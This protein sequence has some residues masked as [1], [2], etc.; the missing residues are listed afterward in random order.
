MDDQQR[1]MKIAAFALC[2]FA[3]LRAPDRDD[4]RSASA[5]EDAAALGVTPCVGIYNG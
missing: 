1:Q 4:T 3:S 5:L 2:R